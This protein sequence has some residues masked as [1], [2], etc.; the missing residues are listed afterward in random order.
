[1]SVLGFLKWVIGLLVP[2]VSR[3]G[4]D[5]FLKTDKMNEYFEKDLKSNR[6]VF[7]QFGAPVHP[8]TAAKTVRICNR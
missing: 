6:V 2:S 1:M 4:L 5:A 3:W 8:G 7:D